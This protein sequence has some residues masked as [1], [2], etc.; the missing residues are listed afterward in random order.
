MPSR[1]DWQILCLHIYIGARSN[2]LIGYLFVTSFYQAGEQIK[3][4]DFQNLIGRSGRSDKHTEGTIIFSYPVFDNKNN[5]LWRWEQARLLLDPENSEPCASVLYSIF[6]D[7][8]SDDKK[9]SF[10]LEPFELIEATYKG[11]GALTA[12][13][14]S[15]VAQHSD[16]QFTI[17]GLQKQVAG[18]IY[19]IAVIELI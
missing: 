14:E 19:L 7:L 17:D 4:R 2:F 13:L 12:I 10:S 1:R 6:N 8:N 5:G 15:I 16:K 11:D 9:Y 18:K 3:V